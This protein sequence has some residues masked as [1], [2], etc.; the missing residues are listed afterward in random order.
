LN[1]ININK[2]KANIEEL[3]IDKPKLKIIRPNNDLPYY[4]Y[5]IPFI[6]IKKSKF[7][8]EDN[9]TLI[10]K[11]KVLNYSSRKLKAL[12]RFL[13]GKSVEQAILITSSIGS[14]GAKYANDY[15]EKIKKLYEK[16]NN[17]EIKYFYI[18]KEAY[19]GT[20]TGTK[21]P[22]PRA[23]GKADIRVSARCRIN[24]KVMKVPA[25]DH[26]Q[27]LALGETDISFSEAIKC[28]L[29]NENASISDIKKNASFL[30]TKGRNYRATQYKRLI[31]YLRKR[32][33]EQ[34]QIKLSN[35]FV[36]EE[37]KRNLGENLIKYMNM[38]PINND[39]FNSLNPLEKA[40]CEIR[41]SF[42]D[43]FVKKL[44]KQQEVSLDLE[45]RK[46]LHQEKMRN[47][48]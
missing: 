41:E 48:Q 23:K 26:L 16:E 8:K 28:K 2:E 42:Y 25:K 5:N 17:N 33:Y 36:G 24:F 11:S 13:I 9:K 3:I 45:K 27:K 47:F 29:F 35:L 6:T 44:S 30:T 31:Y 37:I 38:L 40:K 22:F 39:E 7:D 34:Y 15:L 4:D 12:T 43:T 14:K 21:R 20:K 46:N 1:K 18:I 19:V 10:V 32:Y